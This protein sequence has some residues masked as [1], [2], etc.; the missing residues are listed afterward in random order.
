MQTLPQAARFTQ[1]P[2]VSK[3]NTLKQVS[4]LDHAARFLDDLSLNDASV[5]AE[6]LGGDPYRIL[7]TIGYG[8]VTGDFTRALQPGK[9]IK[10]NTI[11]IPVRNARGLIVAF[12]DQ[13][14]S[15]LTGPA[16]HIANVGRAYHGEIQICGTTSE[17]DSRALSENVCAVGRNGFTDQEVQAAVLSALLTIDPH[18]PHTL[19]SGAASAQAWG[20]AA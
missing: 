1:A 20:I 7:E 15:W 3:G 4:R 13:A 2:A 19:K 17:A 5:V 10:R 6:N 14:L 18:N 9:P 11:I 12:H 8:V 16:V